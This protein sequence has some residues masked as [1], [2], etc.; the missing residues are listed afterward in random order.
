[1]KTLR[2]LKLSNAAVLATSALGLL[3]AAPINTFAQSLEEVVVTAQK[4]AESAQDVPISINALSGEQIQMAGAGNLE[5]LSDSL[6]NVDIAD[7]PG[8]TRVVIRGLGSGTGNAGFEQ[9][10]GMFVDG[11]YASRAALFQAPFLDLA[12]IEV[13]K[14]PQGVLFGKNSIAGALS[15]VSN[16]P[17]EDFE[18]EIS[19]SYE[20]EYDSHEVTGIVSGQ[21]VD[22]LYG[23]VAARTSEDGSY[24]DNNFRG[25]DVPTSEA[26]VVRAVFVWDA[27]DATEVMLKL[28]SGELDE[29]GTN[30]Q[31]FADYSEGTLPDLVENDPDFVPPSAVIG[32]GATIY[33]LARDAGEDFVYDDVSYINED[34][35]LEQNT[36]GLTLQLTQLLGEHELVY[37]FG[38]GS[39]ER[40]QFSDQ[41]FTAPPV[42]ATRLDEEFEQVSHELRI[43]SPTGQV[44]EYIAGLY[45]LDRDFE[46]KSTRDFLGFE[47]L[48]S[49]T[50]HGEYEESSTSYSAFGQA[51][52]NISDTWRTSLGLRYSE[53]EKEASNEGL[54]AVYGSDQ[55][56]L[57]ADPGKYALIVGLFNSP[58]FAYEDERDEDNLDPAFN[59]QWDYS[60]DGMAYVSWTKASKAG[61]FNA[62][63][64][65]G[66]LEDFSYEPEEA[67]SIELGIKTDLLDGRVRLNVAVFRTEFDDLQVG[68]FDPA[69]NGFVVTN[70]A[71]AISQG[72]ELEGLIAITEHLMIGGTAAYLQAE[73][74]NFTAGCPN[75]GVEAASLD[76][77]QDPAGPEGRLIQDL[78]GVQLDNAPEVTAAVFVDYSM[79][80]VGSLIFG[81]RVDASYKDETT[82]DFSQ[83]SNLMEDDFWRVNIRLNLASMDDAWTVALSSFNVTDEQPASFGG[84]EFLVPGAYWANRS[85]GREVELSATYRFGR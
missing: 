16:K 69:V 79:D 25:E 60:P 10:V 36:D 49:F 18:A 51:T 54:I 62:A 64:T 23:R 48:L 21:I 83:D 22:G 71:Q 14:G 6:P 1:M 8:T 65:S 31:T 68:A 15:L 29:S 45:Y 34:D 47:P 70:A 74:E 28:E 81:S 2:P 50:R 37:L 61:G 32:L 57:E 26:D 59:I 12:R 3:A 13:L 55:S 67:E 52:W 35:K 40:D 46:V 5:G 17:T 9:S 76:C 39:Y 44:I 85:R 30:W 78:D 66:L 53:E 75:N 58:I 19:T 72:I 20:F 80:V 43:A 42:V 77:Y 38:Y 56:L 33:S 73:Y 63:E 4:R 7:S 24:M 11:I 84:Q 41:D 82:L 27:T